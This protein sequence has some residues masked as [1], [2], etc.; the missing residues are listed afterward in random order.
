MNF[1]LQTAEK[2]K[3]W[4][5]VDEMLIATSLNGII[6]G[7]FSGQPLMIFGATGPFLIFEEMLYE[8]SPEMSECL[9]I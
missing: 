5:G 1:S 8:V 6:F 3:Y 7:L 9:L 4:F 2:T